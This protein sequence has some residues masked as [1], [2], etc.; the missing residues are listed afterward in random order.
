M[1]KREKIEYVQR[2]RPHKT[3]QEIAD[4]LGVSREMVRRYC[5]L[6]NAPS[7][8]KTLSSALKEIKRLTAL[9]DSCQPKV[10]VGTEL[11]R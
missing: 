1:T 4:D 7:P 11:S 10:I 5:E 6:S 2:E 9:V 8:F 3:L